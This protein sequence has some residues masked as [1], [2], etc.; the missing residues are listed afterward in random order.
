MPTWAKVLFGIG[1]ALV[2]LLIAVGAGVYFF[3]N[4]HKDEWL[5]EGR[6]AREEARTFAA[7][8][9]GADCVEESIRRLRECSGLMCEVRARVF[10]DGCLDAAADSPR[11]C[12]GVPPRSE[13][14]KTVRWSL[15]E[16]SRRGMPG[17]QPCSRLVQ[18]IQK[19]CDRT[20]HR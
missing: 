8:R 1:C 12:E 18:E 16:C 20:L 6:K 15:D 17:S 9:T 19:Y 11:L 14:M 4:R 3:V 7:G 2:L 10:L 13:I 5:A